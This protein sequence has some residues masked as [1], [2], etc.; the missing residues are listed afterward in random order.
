MCGA[1]ARTDATG[2]TAIRACRDP[3]QPPCRRLDA[4]ERA[5][6]T[7]S[8][9]GVRLAGMWCVCGRVWVEG[10]W[11][12][13]AEMSGRCP[14]DEPARPAPRNGAALTSRRWRTRATGTPRRRSQPPT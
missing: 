5:A 1:C 2:H 10:V 13:A 8:R 6:H 7:R 11:R 9:K 4:G 12:V 14:E 3:E